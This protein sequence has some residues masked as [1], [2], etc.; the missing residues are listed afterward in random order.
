METAY[1]DKYKLIAFT[2]NGEKLLRKLVALLSDCHIQEDNEFSAD[3]LMLAGNPLSAENGMSLRTFTANCFQKGNV[4][5]YI[6]A[7]AIAV[8]AIAPFIKDKTKDPAVISIDE[9]GEF[10]IPVLSGHLGGAN[11]EARKIA[12]ILGGTAVITTATDVNHE[13]AVDVFARDNG[14][15]I[16]DM[17]KA[18]E[19]TAKLLR[20]KKGYYCIDER[21]RPYIKVEG[22]PGN[23][24][25]GDRD[26][27]FV[28]SPA[29]AEYEELRLIP[30][31][32]IVGMGCK[33]GKTREELAPFLY[34]N[35]E[36]LGLD[37][38]AVRAIASADI[39]RDEVGLKELANE[40]GTLFLTFSVGKLNA[41]EGDF[42]GSDFVRSVTGVDNVCERAVI[43]C[44][45]R[46]TILHKTAEC[47]MT[48]AI[49]IVDMTITYSL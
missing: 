18:K 17:K 15:V 42:C 3:D 41:Q 26:G 10:V 39:K 14:L 23:I 44:G 30:K 7:V 25:E 31:C 46:K 24:T 33:R 12:S 43:A 16:S 40:L 37:P 13:F 32:I 4:L 47:G 35:L 27:A 29:A 11:T 34:K 38:R 9:K 20:D 19:Y 45:A 2:E 5:I 1:V 21:L 49:G 6:G 28:I 36:K 48:L 8:R 22:M